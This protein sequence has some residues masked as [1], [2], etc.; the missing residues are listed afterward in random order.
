MRIAPPMLLA[1]GILIAAFVA[2]FVA[3]LT[4]GSAA[5][6]TATGGATLLTLALIFG[7]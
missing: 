7:L 6:A 1:L 5:A 4:T 2:G 3:W